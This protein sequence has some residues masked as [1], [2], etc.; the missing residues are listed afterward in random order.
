MR[1]ASSREFIMT[2]IALITGS[3]RGIGAATARLAA[4]R[5][6]A[7]CIN[8]LG[9]EDRARAVADEIRAGGGRA[10][11]AQGDTADESAVARIFEQIDRELGRITSLVNNAGITGKAARLEDYDAAEMRRVL[12]VNVIGTMLCTREATR[13]MSTKHGGSG[14]TVVNLSSVAAVLG[15][16]NNWTPYAAAKGAINSLT[17]GLSREL[18]AE[19]IRVNAIMPGLIETEIHAAAGV[20]DRLAALAPSVPMGRIGTAEEC[21]EL[22]VWLM[23][24]EAAYMTGALIPI[25]GG[26]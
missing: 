23:S 24:N 17:I 15:G 26:R 25:S 14:G 19:S 1:K 13:R 5:G 21:A 8:Y 16:A 11:L 18:A 9:R 12:D 3:G 7:V 2:G 6:Y 10:I 4:K 20:G 22:I